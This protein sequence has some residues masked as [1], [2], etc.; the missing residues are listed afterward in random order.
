MIEHS[1]NVIFIGSLA[2]L[3]ASLGTIVGAVLIWTVKAL[4]VRAQDMLLSS[5][6][7]VMLAASVFS[8]LLPGIAHGEAQGLG[9]GGAATVVSL[10]MLL[11]A[12]VLALIHAFTP[13]QHFFKGREGKDSKRIGGI[14][15]F[16]IAIALH[17]FP[18]GMAVGVGF[19]GGEVSSGIP[20]AVGIF[21]QNIPEGLAVAV[22]LYS[23]GYSRLFGFA[24][25]AG[26]GFIEPVGGLFGATLV[27]IATPILPWI[28]GGA[29]GAMIF[30][31]SNEIIPETHKDGH[32]HAATFSLMAGFGLMMILDTA[33]A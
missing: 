6:A 13:H 3:L 32:E 14:W 31:I 10:G 27:S 25:A 12:A 11:G 16:V 2:S 7:G 26:T 24:V 8:L 21:L 23:I 15:L 22:A 4:S 18:E 9:A 20:L 1:D 30:I 29:A 28:L 5:A 33:L 17:N 19:A